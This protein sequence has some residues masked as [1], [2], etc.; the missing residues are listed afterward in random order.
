LLYIC[1]IFNQLKQKQ[2]MKTNEYSM[3]KLSKTNR[4]ITEGHVSRL[5]DSINKYGYLNS[6]PITVN[7]HFFIID[8]QHRFEA[9]KRLNLPILYEMDNLEINEGQIHLNMTQDKWTSKDFINCHAKKGIKCYQD[10]Q[11]ISSAYG[12]SESVSLIVYAGGA[13]KPSTYKLGETINKSPKSDKIAGLL[14]FFKDKISFKITEKFTRALTH[15]VN[16]D[17][18]EQEINKIKKNA[19]GLVQCANDTQYAEQFKKIVTKR[20]KQ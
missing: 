18:T 4:P 11:T 1:P 10:I 6:R 13:V 15:L 12:I 19:F 14:L 9:C 2:K 7:R 5:V 17:F 20:T 3:F 16:G 8:G